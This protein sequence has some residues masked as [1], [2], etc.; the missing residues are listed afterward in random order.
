MTLPRSQ[1]LL[2]ASTRQSGVASAMA[3]DGVNQPSNVGFGNATSAATHNLVTTIA[4]PGKDVAQR[5]L[6]KAVKNYNYD[7]LGSFFI[8]ALPVLS[9]PV[10]GKFLSQVLPNTVRLN[11]SSMGASHIMFAQDTASV[12]AAKM[13]A[14]RSVIE[15]LET[16]FVEF[17]ES[18]LFYYTAPLV[19]HLL[20]RGLHAGLDKAKINVKGADDYVHWREFGNHMDS[21]GRTVLGKVNDT[22]FKWNKAL[23]ADF[24]HALKT[25]HTPEARWARK[26]IGL[27]AGVIVGVFG[28]LI[29]EYALNFAKNLLT[30]K[31]FK[32]GDFTDVANLT[33][34][35]LK[36]QDTKNHPTAVKARRRIK[37]SLWAALG[38]V[39]AGSALAFSAAKGGRALTIALGILKKIPRWGSFD[40]NVGF[41]LFGQHKAGSFAA[42][43]ERVWFGNHAAGTAVPTLGLGKL[44]KYS[45][46]T[47]GGI[48][49]L[50]A[51]RDK[52]ELK[53]N[54]TRVWCVVM[55]Y[56]M[57]GHNVL[58]E[59]L[60]RLGDKDYKVGR[61]VQR[62][63]P[64]IYEL[65]NRIQTVDKGGSP[66]FM[67]H[68]DIL[69]T[70]LSKAG[71]NDVLPSRGDHI[72]YQNTLNDLQ[73]SH[74]EAH[75]IAIEEYKRL[76]Q[77]KNKAFLAPFTF[78]VLVVGMTVAWLNRFW[79]DYRFSTQ[80]KVWADTILKDLKQKSVQAVFQNLTYSSTFRPLGS[81]P[82][83][84]QFKQVGY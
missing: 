38:I 18:G 33:D 19:G 1:P 41:K 53:E 54:F 9:I 30:L 81:L 69:K 2:F 44:L 79:T 75:K 15:G 32:T 17:V 72:V 23:H 60:R 61:F 16:T 57:F 59:Q 28:A 68:K 84:P 36:K 46:I 62:Q 31:L 58:V 29:G 24:I 43:R 5:V 25:T 39:G 65:F 37:Q 7:Q 4:G 13:T 45:V 22:D 3:L 77:A 27:K 12:W 49:Y 20:S 40:F 47:L 6:V 14:M 66:A 73:K 76:M 64:S 21:I 34:R 26:L 74:P 83:T 55:P 56:L 63:F 67:R 50:D 8:K 42:L 71:L 70:A 48:G 52:L 11:E 51:S 35:N 78:G 10:I 82:S 80:R